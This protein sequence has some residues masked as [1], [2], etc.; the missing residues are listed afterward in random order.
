MKP[1]LDHNALN[2]PVPTARVYADIREYPKLL[3]K[4]SKGGIFPQH[5]LDWSEVDKED[6]DYRNIAALLTMT[7]FAG[8]NTRTK[9][10]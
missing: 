6:P 5:M 10:G 4:E 2:G 7:S 8:P 3:S 1:V 9:I